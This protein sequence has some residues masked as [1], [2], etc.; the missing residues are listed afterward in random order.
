MINELDPSEL[1]QMIKNNDE[2]DLVDVREDSELQI[3]KLNYTHHIPIASIPQS[4]HK[5]DKA[6]KTV[7][8][9]RSGGRSFNCAQYLES[10][11]FKNVYNLTGGIL[12]W[13]D[14]IDHNIQKY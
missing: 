1:A 3:C 9:C 5:L 14:K 10:N 6:R 2:F 11:G 12:A 13:S 4:I 8:Y 7:I